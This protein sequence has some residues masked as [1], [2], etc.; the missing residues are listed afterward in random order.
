MSE[1]YFFQRYY[2]KENAHSSNALLLLKRV[3]FYNPKI[4]YKVLSSWAGGDEREFLPSFIAQEKGNGSVPDFC[5]RQNGFELIVEAKEKNNP[6]SKNQ[7]LRHLASFQAAEG[8]KIFIALAPVFSENDR[9]NFDEVTEKG[10]KI[11]PLTYL[12][13]YESLIR[14]CDERNDSELIELIEEYH[15]YC[16]EENLIDDTDNTIMVRSVG[17]TIEFNV[18]DRVYFDKFEHRYEGFR[19]LALYNNKRIKYIG[20]IYK[21]AKAYK[22]SDGEIVMKG[23]TPHDCFLDEDEKERIK[24]AMT[25]QEK[26]YGN[27]SEAHSYFLVEDFEP[28]EN[29][30]KQSKNPLFGKKKFYLSQFGLPKNSSVKLI[31]EKMKNKSWEEI[32]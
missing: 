18:K 14:V 2:T 1:V 21:V 25:N 30:V 13:L 11:L 23:L 32:E 22:M 3:Y 17:D 8:T 27:T 7:L 19:Y 26:L 24:N 9:K 10:I 16:N 6:F 4:F 5:I 12:D 29:F 15:D 28:V 31:A 20:R